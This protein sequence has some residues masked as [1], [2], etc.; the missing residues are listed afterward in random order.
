MFPADVKSTLKLFTAISSWPIGVLMMRDRPD[1]R[2]AE[3]SDRST[4]HPVE[5]TPIFG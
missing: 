3:S 1:S 5:K 2:C 4:S